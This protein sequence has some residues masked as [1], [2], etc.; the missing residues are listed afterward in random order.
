M[1]E[2]ASSSTGRV[3]PV[4]V[5]FASVKVGLTKASPRSAPG[6]ACNADTYSFG[7]CPCSN[8]VAIISAAERVN[9]NAA[10]FRKP[11]SVR[12]SGLR[13]TWTRGPHRPA[14]SVNTEGLGLSD[15]RFRRRLPW[16]HLAKFDRPTTPQE[17]IQTEF[18]KRK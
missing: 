17:S 2:G 4:N 9:A 11:I 12:N 3:K 18:R 16:R 6:I 13:L 1:A 15:S 14:V 5:T 8:G 10:I 7:V